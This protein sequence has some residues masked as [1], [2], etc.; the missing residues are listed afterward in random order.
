MTPSDRL[1]ASIA[2][3]ISPPRP[4]SKTLA[5]GFGPGTVILFDEHFN[6][7]GWRDHEYKAF[8]EFVA[9]RSLR[10]RYLAYNTSEWNVAVKIL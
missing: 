2:T 4:S 9:S 5:D 10:C 6:Y 3:C 7:P 1:Q 8:Q